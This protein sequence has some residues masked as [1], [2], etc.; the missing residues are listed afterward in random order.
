MLLDL[1][2]HLLRTTAFQERLGLFTASSSIILSLHRLKPSI[3]KLFK[4]LALFLYAI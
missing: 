2:K 1:V 4:P 3:F